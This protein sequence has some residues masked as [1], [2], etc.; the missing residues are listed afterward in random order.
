MLRRGELQQVIWL[1][2]TPTFMIGKCDDPNFEQHLKEGPYIVFDDSAKPKYR[3]DPRVH[4]VPGHPVLQTAMP[5]VME[6]LGLQYPGRA[7]MRW[8]QFER[9]GMSNVEYGTPARKVLAVAKPIAALGLAAAAVWGAAAIT[10]RLL[11]D[12]NTNDSS[13]GNE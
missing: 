3:D 6:G 4:F 7:V 5:S 10:N 11:G 1:K 8:Q 13:G 2:G 9:W 12:R